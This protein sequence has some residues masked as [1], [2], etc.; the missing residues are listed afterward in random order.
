MRSEIADFLELYF[1]HN[2]DHGGIMPYMREGIQADMA[3]T[4]ESS[5]VK[6][7]S[8]DAPVTPEYSLTNTRTLGV[9]EPEMVKT[10]GKFI[11][12]VRTDSERK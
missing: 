1:E 9:D 6:G 7:T 11:Y 2:R 3:V 5:A 4:A 8:A 12:S 10:D